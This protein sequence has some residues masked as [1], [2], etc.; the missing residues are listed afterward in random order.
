M[1][2]INLFFIISFIMN[3]I[4]YGM[5]KTLKDS[6]S[7]KEQKE[8]EEIFKAKTEQEKKI[9]ELTELIMNTIPNPFEN[10]MSSF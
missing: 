6:S 8:L 5:Q 10:S 7:D 4:T 1:K 2:I 9:D 3:T